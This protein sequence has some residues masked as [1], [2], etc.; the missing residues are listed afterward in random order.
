MGLISHQQFKHQPQYV[1]S[2]S[3]HLTQQA[4]LKTSAESTP[5]L[6]LN[7]QHH[8]N[9]NFEH[10][11]IH[12]IQTLMIEL[13]EQYCGLMAK[14]LIHEIRKANQVSSLKICQMQWITSL[15]ESRIAPILLNQNLQKINAAIQQVVHS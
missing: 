3:G 1:N 13:L 9:P 8:A 7:M 15:Q 5:D 2:S 14:P 11:N 6:H 12:Q 10:L 4:I